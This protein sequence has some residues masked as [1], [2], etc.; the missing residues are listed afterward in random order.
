VELSR[1]H[2]NIERLVIHGL[3]QGNAKAL[4]EALQANLR[5]VLLD[6]AGR[7]KWARPHRTPVL[8]LGRMPLADGNA[9]AVRFG[10][11]LAGAIGKGLKP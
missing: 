4:T 8:K 7:E 9:G 10:K 6:R 5:Q 1:I 2:V 3:E 11:T